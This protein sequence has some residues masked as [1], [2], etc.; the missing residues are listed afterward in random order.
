MNAST[1]ETLQALALI[2]CCGL[3][4]GYALGR[5]LALAFVVAP[6]VSAATATFAVFA[7]LIVGGA[8]IPWLVVA[9]AVQCV[10][11]LLLV[12][13][14]PVRRF[15]L[16]GW[17]EARW[18]LL[19]L[20]LPLGMVL[21]LPEAWDANSIWW[22]HAAYF[23]PGSDFA[24]EAIASPVTV[25]SHT[26]YPPLSSAPV[27]AA[28]AVLGGGDRYVAQFV[29]A[30]V[31]FSAVATLVYGVRY[32]TSAARPALSRFAA[33]AVGLSCWGASWY[34]LANG[35]ADALWSC[36]VAAAAVLLLVGQDGLRRPGLVMLLL[37]VSALAKN[38]GLT[39][40]FF[41]AALATLRY[42]RQWRRALLLW[43]PI[44]AGLGWEVLVRRLG[45]VS[46]VTS[47][48]RL[49]KLFSGDPL[50]LHRVRM[51]VDAI[52]VRIGPML[53]CA[54]I[55][56]VVGSL[57]LRTRRRRLGLAED[58]WLWAFGAL[59]GAMLLSVYVSTDG[60]LNWWLGTSVDRTTLLL[61]LVGCIS[62]ACWLV[63]AAS[64]RG[65]REPETAESDQQVAAP[66]AVLD[67][68]RTAPAPAGLP[69][70][71]TPDRPGATEHAGVVRSAS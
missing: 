42:H 50:L 21:A 68:Q 62:A 37:S 27:S 33:V 30:A 40:A 22:L 57:L 34:V 26:D 31:T 55:L 28:W 4:L 13:R 52:W 7:M 44:I 59:Y 10:A 48:P 5:N 2:V 36:A 71:E 65:S 63:V 61:A 24:R 17:A 64:G 11:A 39:A 70:A 6:M 14:W 9:L 45:A 43:P 47:G 60:D 25:F 19:P 69:D 18:L 56:G 16:P 3:P 51:T 46:D 1:A 8:L 32:V 54:V 23:V 35:Y 53:V 58:A 12:F 49:T 29:S 15:P 67:T 38:E 41:L 66:A 20:L